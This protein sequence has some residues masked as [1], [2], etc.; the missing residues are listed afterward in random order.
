M[1]RIVDQ[2]LIDQQNI[3]QKRGN[4]RRPMIVQDVAVTRE[5]IWLSRERHVAPEDRGHSG[6]GI[7]DQ[8]IGE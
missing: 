6:H 3:A 7:Q 5:R 8:E 1:L 4:E 2:R